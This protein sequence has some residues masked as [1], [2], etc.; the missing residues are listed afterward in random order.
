M[1]ILII[2]PTAKL[3][4][5]NYGGTERVIWYLAK[6]LSKMGHRVNMLVAPGSE[7]PFADITEYRDDV[8]LAQQIPQGIDII[9]YQ[10]RADDSLGH[11]PHVVT[12]HGNVCRGELDANTIFVSRNH[13]ERFGSDCYVYNG[14]DW[15]DYGQADLACERSY[16]HFLG[17]AAWRVKNVKGAIDVVK[18]V[19]GAR[20]KVLGGHRFNFKMGIRLTFSPKVSFYGMV[21]GGQKFRLLNGSRGLIF[22]VLW[23]E[24]FGLAI[25]ESLYFGAPVF[26][27]PFGSLP[28]LVN[29]DVGYLTDSKSD[30]ASHIADA[31]HYS[32]KLCHDYAVDNFNSRLMAERYLAKY[33]QVLNGR[34]LNSG[35]LKANA[36][37]RRYTWKQ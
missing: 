15:D 8:P 6:E 18:A 14:M 20:L 10:E 33:E 16:F 11:I 24:P 5:V 28:E 36:N 9:H 2:K 29:G 1:N 31:C 17:K 37:Y 34:P 19:P 27:T 26:G 13:A 22:P 3:P 7:C 23:D 21:G 4:V 25:T 35:K 30:M 32:S 12:V